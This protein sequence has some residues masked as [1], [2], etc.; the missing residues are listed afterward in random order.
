M[1]KATNRKT[2]VG[3]VVSNAMEKTVVV[4]VE[5][6]VQHPVFLKYIRRKNKF[7]AHD[8][9]R[10]CKTGDTVEIMECRPLSRHKRWCVTRVIRRMELPEQV[11]AAVG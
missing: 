3:T 4:E 1:E 11:E 9:K 7:M 2:K 6:T 5:R 10:E 8:E